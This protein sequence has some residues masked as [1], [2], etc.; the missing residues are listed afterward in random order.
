MSFELDPITAHVYQAREEFF[1]LEKERAPDAYQRLRKSNQ[2]FHTHVRESLKYFSIFLEQRQNILN[3]HLS[4]VGFRGIVA[5][6][7]SYFYIHPSMMAPPQMVVSSVGYHRFFNLHV[8]PKQPEK[9]DTL[10]VEGGKNT[11]IAR[12]NVSARLEH[13]ALPLVCGSRTLVGTTTSFIDIKRLT[14]SPDLG[15]VIQD[16]LERF[17]HLE[18]GKEKASKPKQLLA[19]FYHYIPAARAVSL[20]YQYGV[21]IFFEKAPKTMLEWMDAREMMDNRVLWNYPYERPRK[22]TLPFAIYTAVVPPA[23]K[24]VQLAITFPQS[25][26]NGKQPGASMVRYFWS[27][28]PAADMRG[29]VY[30]SFFDNLCHFSPDNTEWARHHITHSF[31]VSPNDDLYLAFLVGPLKRD[32]TPRTRGAALGSSSSHAVTYAHPHTT[33]AW[34]DLRNW[35]IIYLNLIHSKSEI[36]DASDFER[37]SRLCDRM[38]QPLEHAIQFGTFD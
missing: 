30:K 21:R 27:S 31:M 16:D 19:H 18:L 34:R 24:E 5:I 9:D 6:V 25:E 29:L 17:C 20:I 32:T 23:I 28:R 15:E 10:R 37:A 3:F 2:D 38:R 13:M 33:D 26:V 7:K 11:S 35:H 36:P 14:L 1:S 8:I 12:A 4:I 22:N